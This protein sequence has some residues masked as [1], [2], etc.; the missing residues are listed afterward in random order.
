MPRCA[1]APRLPPHFPAHDPLRPPAARREQRAALVHAGGHAPAA[2]SGHFP[3]HPARLGC[4]ATG[5]ATRATTSPDPSSAIRRRQRI[6]RT[7]MSAQSAARPTRRPASVSIAAARTASAG[8]KARGPHVDADPDHRR[9][10]PIA[11]ARQR[12]GQDP[13]DLAPCGRGGA[14]TRQ[15]RDDVVRP[16][17][18]RRHPGGPLH[19]LGHGDARQQRDDRRLGAP[20]EE[21]I[22]TARPPAAN[23]TPARAGHG[24]R[25]GGRR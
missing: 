22:R 21:P 5:P 12:L 15:P 17:Q 23:P 16:L 14:V 20:A 11:P 9:G 24:R 10:A 7:S 18:F 13:G 3:R 19:R 4:S 8:G 2:G 25:S 6:N 1:G